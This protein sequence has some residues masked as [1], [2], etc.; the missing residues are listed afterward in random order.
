MEGLRG[1][2][3]AA[4]GKGAVLAVYLPRA[5]GLCRARGR[6]ARPSSSS[7]DEKT[8]GKIKAPRR[9]G[10]R[11]RQSQAPLL[12]GAPGLQA[13]EGA[14]WVLARPASPRLSLFRGLSQPLCQPLAL[15]LWL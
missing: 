9:L 12:L 13:K 11:Q 7:C 4:D 1:D 8:D 10:W 3:K 15:K 5:A 6:V 2:L 14:G